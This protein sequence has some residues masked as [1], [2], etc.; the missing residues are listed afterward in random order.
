MIHVINDAAREDLGLTVSMTIV[1]IEH[2]R[3]HASGATSPERR[4]SMNIGSTRATLVAPTIAKHAL[5]Y[6]HR[7][8][9]ANSH[10]QSPSRLG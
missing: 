3:D 4:S 5:P 6:G 8:L 10:D 7:V 2:D 1:I 9:L